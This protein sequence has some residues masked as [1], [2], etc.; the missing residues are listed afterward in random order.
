M[1][2]QRNIIDIHSSWVYDDQEISIMP[3][4]VDEE[5]NIRK[6]D[7]AIF[8]FFQEY[9]F[10]PEDFVTRFL[11]QMEATYVKY[12]DIFK[13]PLDSSTDACTIR[14]NKIYV[15]TE[16]RSKFLALLKEYHLENHITI[17]AHFVAEIFEFKR[18]HFKDWF[19]P[20][21]IEELKLIEKDMQKLEELKY[22][23]HNL[24]KNNEPYNSKLIINIRAKDFKFKTDYFIW[25][26]LLRQIDIQSRNKLYQVPPGQENSMS[27]PYHNNYPN[28]FQNQIIKAIYHFLYNETDFPFNNSK[29][30]IL[31]VPFV[32]NFLALC[33]PKFFNDK[34]EEFSFQDIDSETMRKA[35]QRAVKK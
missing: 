34:G 2:F 20:E 22:E 14:F 19:R 12:F 23:L 30:P 18:K 5:N 8:N 28:F 16:F 6:C 27:L 35:I 1:E 24:N 10:D 29:V 26:Y 9:E 7:Y 4:L 15:T 31:L 33:G 32:I 25:S 13:F 17:L 3:E 21:G 11:P